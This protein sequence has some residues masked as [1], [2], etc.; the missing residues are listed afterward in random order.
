MAAA[1]SL[2][3]IPL[4]AHLFQQRRVKLVPRP[5]DAG[6]L[7]AGVLPLVPA[8]FDPFGGTIYLPAR[9]R[10]L[11]W[12]KG[13]VRSLRHLNRGDWLLYEAFSAVHDYL[14]VWAV[15]ELTAELFGDRGGIVEVTP[16]ILRD[17]EFIYLVSEA[18][19]TV[20][21][22]FWYL[23]RI[24]ID[25]VCRLGSNFRGLA[26]SYRE[27]DL[28]RYRALA[29]DFRVQ[30]PA[31]LTWM[32]T[33]YCALAFEQFSLEDLRRDTRLRG[34]LGHELRMARKQLALI[35][36][37]LSHL[38]GW[39]QSKTA[40]VEFRSTRRREAVA[41][42]A[43][44]LW[45]ISNGTQTPVLRRASLSLPRRDC[46]R[47]D[48]RFTNIRTLPEWP[49]FDA[50]ALSRIGVQ[51]FAYFAYQYLTAFEFAGARRAQHLR[52][53][54]EACILTRDFGRL[55]LL[56][57]SRQKPLAGAAGPADLIFAD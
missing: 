4:V 8:G 30:Q 14:H 33:G 22:D 31:F 15:A 29:P 3:S 11:D 32:V 34:W 54:V 27:G 17:V 57:G 55:R 26:S 42:V 51:Q 43:E 36:D 10:M 28:S 52:R 56:T 20:G 12:Q 2:L 1:A 50:G 47:I 49:D 6:W 44:K 25:A 21:V 7:Y 45:C 16:A 13:S 39:P 35:R 41:R 40:R 46:R 48:Y 53:D 9:S 23:S 37:W 38:T 19:A 18:V 24:D 5:I